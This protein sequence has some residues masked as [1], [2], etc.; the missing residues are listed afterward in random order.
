[1][2]RS[3]R[4]LIPAIL[5][6]I[7]LGGARTWSDEL[8]PWFVGAL[9]ADTTYAILGLS[10]DSAARSVRAAN[11]PGR[12]TLDAD[13]GAS[14]TQ[15][16]GDSASTTILVTP[17]AAVGLPEPYHTTASV[18]VPITISASDGAT[19]SVEPSISVSQPLN[20]LLGLEPSERATRLSE[21]LSTEQ[22]R[23]DLA[24]RGS[25]VKQSVLNALKSIINAEL[26]LAKSKRALSEAQRTLEKTA[27]LES[28][29]PES[30]A[31]RAV[32]LA[33]ERAKR[34]V[35]LAEETRSRVGLRFL[36]LTGT[37][38]DETLWRAVIDTPEVVIPSPEQV[39]ENPGAYLAR[40]R[41]ERTTAE[42]ELMEAAFIPVYTTGLSYS[43][44]DPDATVG[45]PY[46]HTLGGSFGAVFER[47]SIRAGLSGSLGTTDSLSGSVSFDWSL[48]D[49][50]AQEISI[51][52]KRNA[53]SI[54]ELRLDAAINS[55]GDA[56]EELRRA[57]DS[58]AL[59]ELVLSEDREL[60][61]MERRELAERY[62]G[63]LASDRDLEAAGWKLEQLDYVERLIAI[64]R[65]LL[66]L[67][68][69][70]LVLAGE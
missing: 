29:N 61:E 69:D 48:P 34:S 55:F 35:S 33:V 66:A 62:E 11:L 37:E 5:T 36:E 64:D 46:R 15:S 70:S 23:L 54:A 43:M 40:L 42:L 32:E 57:A 60:A 3:T 41:A 59:R 45:A 10:L 56:V 30:A 51:E 39:D 53:L 52:Q 9:E 63:G 25:A 14:I 50:R 24:A 4:V 58:L 17:G 1:M 28:V 65:Y 68:A 20:D 2:F 67:Q 47:F 12:F 31:Y 6:L 8:E 27:A 38:A 16:F 13:A 22:T 21:L 19:M 7:M 18:D 49:D 26:D 44:S